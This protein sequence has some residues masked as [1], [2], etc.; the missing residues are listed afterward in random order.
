MQ[1]TDPR[2]NEYYFLNRKYIFAWAQ[3]VNLLF[4]QRKPTELKD[5]KCNRWG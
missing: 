3:T 2:I 4:K 1:V 5:E